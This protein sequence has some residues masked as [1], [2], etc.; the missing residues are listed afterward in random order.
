MKSIKR[1]ILQKAKKETIDQIK[2]IETDITIRSDSPDGY[3]KEKVHFLN[4]S[5]GIFSKILKKFSIF[6]TSSKLYSFKLSSK[7][8]KYK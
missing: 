5:T 4:N 1:K 8:L 6:G 2:K 7:Y 3:I